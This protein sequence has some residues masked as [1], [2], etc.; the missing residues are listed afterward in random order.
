M[1]ASYGASNSY[2]R[3][4]FS[5]KKEITKT[6]RCGDTDLPGY[7]LLKPMAFLFFVQRAWIVARRQKEKESYTQIPLSSSS[8]CS[9]LEN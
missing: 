1:A 3:L 6:C 7:I 9:A 8:D 5:F 2:L 4:K